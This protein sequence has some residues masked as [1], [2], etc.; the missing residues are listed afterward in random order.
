MEGLR[1]RS[2]RHLPRGWNIGGNFSVV[3]LDGEQSGGELEATLAALR[4]D[5]DIALAVPDERVKAQA[6]IPNDPLFGT[7]WYL[8]GTEV[9]AIR[10]HDAWDITRGGTS[11]DTST[12]VVAVIDSGVR[13][14]HPDLAGKLLPGWDFVSTSQVGNDGDG[15]DDDPSDPG[16]WMTAEELASPTWSSGKCGGGTNQDQPTDSSWHGTRVAGM[17]AAAS[18]N[19][20]GMTGAAFNV[21][22]LPLRVLG[23]C[24]GYVSDVIAAMYWAA[25]MSPPPP[26]MSTPVP[27]VNDTPAKI[28]NVSLGS[29]TPCSSDSNEV[30]RVAVRQITEHGT[31]IVASAGNSGAAVGAP[32]GCE[33]VLAVAGLR[34]AGTKVGY[35]SLGPEVSVSAPA[36]NCVNTGIGAPCIFAINSATNLGLQGPEANGYSTQTL[37]PTYGTSFSSPLVAATAALMLSVNPGLSPRQLIQLVQSSAR[38]FPTLSDTSP[39]PAACVLPSVTAVQNTECICTTQVCGAGM[40]DTAAAVLAAQST[41]PEPEENGGGGGSIDTLLPGVL[42][43]LGMSRRRRR[44]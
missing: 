15:W 24:G 6:Y 40:L 35:S 9:S 31:L 38:P 14:D 2:G 27:P 1:L 20:E 13:F 43:L 12:V 21:R 4:A 32:A 23:K 42:L 5:P 3:Q 34:H 28:I 11:P 10:A 36:G 16:D 41:T 26:Y 37:Q 33:G 22:V 39:Q 44:S 29:D 17:I 19:A 30:Y 18:D 25:G 8:Q 7:Q